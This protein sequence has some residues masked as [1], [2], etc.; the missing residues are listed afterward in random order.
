MLKTLF[1]KSTP[2]ARA[3]RF[4]KGKT[5]PSEKIPAA[6]LRTKPARLPEVTELDVVRHFTKASQ[7]NYSVDTNFYPLGSCTMKYNPKASFRAATHPVFSNTHPFCPA[8][9][10]QGLLEVLKEFEKELLE[11]TGMNALTLTP[12]AGAHSELTAILMAREYFRDRGEIKRNKVIIPDSAHGTN[13]ASAAL[14]GFEVVTIHSNNK[15]RIDL[16]ALKKV[17]NDE[18]AMLMVTLPNT[19]G[20]FEEDILEVSRLVHNVGALLYMDGA[21][22]NALMG[23]VKPGD[24]GFDVMHLNLHKTFSVPHGGGGPGAGILLVKSQLEEFLP[25]PR[26]IEEKGEYR[27]LESSPKSIGRIRSF[28]GSTGNLLWSAA[29]V[30][31]LGKEGIR[32]A[33]RGAILNANYLRVLLTQAGL[34]PHRNE[35]CMH[36][37]V[38]T[39][40]PKK[41][42]GVRTLDI[43][44]RLLDFGVYAPTIYFPMIVPEA[45]MVEPTE[46]E[47]LETLEEFAKTVAKILKEAKDNPERVKSAP[48]K[49]P[50]RR[51]DEITAARNPILRWQ[52]N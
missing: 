52:K 33:T 42:N 36:E 8:W 27:V 47:S 2:G 6:L 15:G 40:D 24:I 45:I 23:V 30:A 32:E 41:L 22:M 37:C 19:L 20:L 51:L 1:E 12:A 35:P 49:L 50:V 44:K 48:H 28:F 18:T 13:P 26:I 31:L 29:Y 38:F 14:G 9:A 25:V 5:H 46:T 4:P 11:I 7:L 21:N 39:L 34:A 17:L 16:E 3:T 43:A 10:V